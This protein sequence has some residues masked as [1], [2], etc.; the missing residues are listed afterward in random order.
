MLSNR[1]G[2]IINALFILSVLAIT[3]SGCAAT[4]RQPEKEELKEAETKAAPAKELLKKEKSEL[5]RQYQENGSNSTAEGNYSRALEFFLKANEIMPENDNILLSIGNALRGLNRDDEAY[6]YFQRALAINP[7]S[8]QS[9]RNIG[10]IKRERKQYPESI[11]TFLK[12]LEIEP[13]DR[14]SIVNLADLYFMNKEYELSN[15]YIYKFYETLNNVSKDDYK[16]V[17]DVFKRFNEY[18]IVI[19]KKTRRR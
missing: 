15:Q 8:Y 2:H 6:K 13:Y 9:L 10:I 4:S 12:V 14:D 5:V 18:I 17:G 11:N 19:N 7:E 16:K 3:I 1:I